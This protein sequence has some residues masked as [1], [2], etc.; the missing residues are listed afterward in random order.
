MQGAVITTPPTAPR[1]EAPVRSSARE[2]TRPNRIRPRTNLRR[3]VY[4]RVLYCGILFLVGATSGIHVKG[5][6][7]TVMSGLMLLIA[8][9]ALLKKWTVGQLLPVA[10]A[11]VGTLGWIVSSQIN[12]IAITDQRIISWPSFA[13]YLIGIVVLVGRNLEQLFALAVGVAVGSCF[14]Y[15][16]SGLPALGAPS[17]ENYWKYAFAPWITLIV[18]YSLAVFG[19]ALRIQALVLILLAFTSLAL[20]YRSHALVCIGAAA[21]VLVT[22]YTRDRLARWMQIVLVGITG[23]VFGSIVPIIA[24]TGIAGQALKDKVETQ[25]TTGAPAIFAG[26][27]ESPLSMSAISEKPWFGWGNANYLTDEVFAKGESLAV[28]IGF[29][30]TLDITSSWRLAN[31]DTS[32]H[33]ILLNGWAE[34]GVFVALLPMALIGMAIAIVWNSS[35]YGIWSALA[36]VVATQALWDL[37]FSPLSYNLLTILAVLAAIFAARHLP[38]W[39][40]FGADPAAPVDA[41]VDGL[42]TAA[43]RR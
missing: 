5:Y 6:T 12:V 32:L 10:L 41:D 42:V 33:S 36:L 2:V 8:P 3:D 7:L 30:P 11:F 22:H 21:V 24:R 28:K 39:T 29:D 43:G 4:P 9:A 27:T 16:T 17:F 31:G 34:G 40:G 37:F 13:L 25:D 19:V 23:A 35:R 1:S 26:R 18:L 20:N 38:K 15:L 14:Y